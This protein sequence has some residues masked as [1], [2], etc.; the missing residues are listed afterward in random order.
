M[1]TRNRYKPWFKD[2]VKLPILKI[3]IYGES[4]VVKYLKYKYDHILRQNR[5]SF[6]E[7][8]GKLL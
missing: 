3:P 6:L 2:N 5:L 1:G 7:A 8:N 4:L